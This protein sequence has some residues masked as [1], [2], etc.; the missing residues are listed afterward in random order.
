[1][2]YRLIFFFVK[3]SNRKAKIQFTNYNNVI[4]LISLYIFQQNTL[5]FKKNYS[6]LLSNIVFL[7]GTAPSNCHWK[8]EWVSF[9]KLNK[10][11][12][13][14]SFWT[15]SKTEKEIAPCRANGTQTQKLQVK[16]N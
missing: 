15:E 4:S 1:M 13:T 5:H 14:A 3:Q 2:K 12:K 8:R 11:N 9:C 10:K 6:L 7:T 16:L